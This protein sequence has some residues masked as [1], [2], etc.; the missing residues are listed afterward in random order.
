[1]SKAK[2]PELARV[3]AEGISNRKWP[4]GSLPPLMFQEVV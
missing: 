1:M 3:L 4:V 2:Y